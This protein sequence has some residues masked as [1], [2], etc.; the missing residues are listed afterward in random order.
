MRVKIL[1]DYGGIYLD[2]DMEII[3]D[4]SSLLNSDLFLGYENEDTM[5]FGIVGV[6]PKHK[7]FKKMYEFLSK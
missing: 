1:Y 2:T 7:V 3:K 6:I 4:I 5:S